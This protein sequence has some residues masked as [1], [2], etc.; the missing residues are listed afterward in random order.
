MYKKSVRLVETATDIERMLLDLK[1][2]EFELFKITGEKPRTTRLRLQRQHYWMKEYGYDVRLTF[3]HD[4]EFYIE[5]MKEG[6]RKGFVNR[7]AHSC[8]LSDPVYEVKRV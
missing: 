4:N 7:R 8:P 1:E 3:L 6:D 2:G 5:M